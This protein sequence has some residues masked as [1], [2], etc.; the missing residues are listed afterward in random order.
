MQKVMRPDD[1]ATTLVAGGYTERAYEG[2][3]GSLRSISTHEGIGRAM[4]DSIRIR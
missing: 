3:H 2:T 1:G 4:L